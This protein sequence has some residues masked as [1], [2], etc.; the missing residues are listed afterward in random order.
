[1][2]IIHEIVSD[3][4]LRS[5]PP[6]IDAVQGDEN[7]RTVQIRLYDHQAEWTVPGGAAV[8]IRYRKP[9][10]TGGVYDTLADGTPAWRA[11]GHVITILLAPELLSAA[12]IVDASVAVTTENQVLGT[13]IFRIHVAEDPSA[14]VP[15][16]GK[17]YNLGST[18]ADL[19]AYVDEKVAAGSCQLTIEAVEAEEE[20]ETAAVQRV[21]LD[22]T[23]L[24]MEIGES[25]QLAASVSPANAAN[26]AVLWE[27]SDSS[28]AKVVNG[29]VTAVAAGSCAITAKS[30]ENAG[31]FAAC[32]VAVTAA[33]ESGD[34][35]IPVT[36]LT[37]NQTALSLAEGETAQLECTVSPSD[38]TNPAVGWESSDSG[39]AKVSGGLVTA[40]A[41]GD[42]G[43]TAKSVENTAITAVCA[44][45][46]TAA[47]SGSAT[48]KQYFDEIGYTA[49]TYKKDGTLV[50]LD[51][52]YH[53]NDLAYSEGMTISTRQNSAWLN[54][55][56]PFL[57]DTTGGYVV[58][59]YETVA[60]H[61]YKITLSGYTNINRV[62]VNMYFYVGAGQTQ[63]EVFESY[64]EY[65]YVERV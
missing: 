42:C 21:T 11:E 44:V 46:V 14:D 38:A 51:S 6:V 8:L 10:G 53:V 39:V 37:L 36:A 28:V 29:L 40:V 35:T 9:D 5:P 23:S 3:F 27:S 13:F 55:Y 57:L 49:Q 18:I 58:P 45:N 22:Y 2:Q 48:G 15:E 31:I 26:T 1:M 24:A 50:T 64:K 12:G 43:I 63:A 4:A 33:S 32:A 60:N 54:N 30:A 20:D 7:T 19:K 65:F 52:G 61:H 17:Y 34:T 59:D 47:S 16:A 56:P 41:A 25:I 62:L